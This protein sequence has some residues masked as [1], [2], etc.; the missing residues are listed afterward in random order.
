M[1]SVLAAVMLALIPACEAGDSP[2]GNRQQAIAGGP[3]DYTFVPDPARK[4]PP[5]TDPA[6]PTVKALKAR[7]LKQ[8]GWDAE[9]FSCGPACD[10]VYPYAIF[11][12]RQAK[13][14]TPAEHRFTCPNPET[15]GEQEEWRCMPYAGS[16]QKEGRR[17]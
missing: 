16:F 14:P 5:V 15:P 2:P 10:A 8:S 7:G 17:P 4:Y 9:P 6:A 13:L 3:E 1:R 12:G 11:M